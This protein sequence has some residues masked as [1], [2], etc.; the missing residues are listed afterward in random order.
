M[1]AL[2]VSALRSDAAICDECLDFC[3]LVGA[4]DHVTQAIRKGET[5]VGTFLMI[6]PEL[7][8][9][10]YGHPWQ[11][12]FYFDESRPTRLVTDEDGRPLGYR[13]KPDGTPY[14]PPDSYVPLPEGVALAA[15]RAFA[16]YEGSHRTA[17]PRHP[18]DTQSRTE[19]D[20]RTRARRALLV[21][22]YRHFRVLEP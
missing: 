9:D 2:A 7:P 12:L 15:E 14:A 16:E 3:D 18:F 10:P 13:N 1:T 8:R 4:K 22:A 19:Y 21:H 11:A 17:V 6:Q 5:G 20:D